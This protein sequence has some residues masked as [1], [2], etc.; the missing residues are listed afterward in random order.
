MGPPI[1][2][3]GGEKSH[4]TIGKEETPVKRKILVLL[5]ASLVA[6]MLT[7]APAFAGTH[8]HH[9]HPTVV[10]MTPMMPMM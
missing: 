1:E 3:S 7:A 5:T 4:P 10:P 9:H 2:R 6:T 8:H